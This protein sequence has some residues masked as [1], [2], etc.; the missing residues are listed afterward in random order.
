M[1]TRSQSIPVPEEGLRHHARERQG[2][3]VAHASSGATH[4][5]GSC[6]RALSLGLT[7]S[8]LQEERRRW[9]TCFCCSGSPLVGGLQQRKKDGGRKLERQERGEWRLGAATLCSRKR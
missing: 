3:L 6:G 1:A 8:T 7:S 5:A 2:L 9:L 4:G